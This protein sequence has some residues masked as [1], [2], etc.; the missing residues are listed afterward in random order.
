MPEIRCPVSEAARLFGSYPA[1]I[2]SQSTITYHEYDR[3]VA[4]TQ[5]RLQDHGVAAHQRVAILSENSPEY[6]ILLAAL[7]RL[8]AVAC[9]ISPHLPVLSL[10]A[11]LERIGCDVIIYASNQVPLDPRLTT[12]LLPLKDIVNETI[13]SPTSISDSF[14]SPDQDAT[15][16]ATSGTTAVPK[17]VLHSYGNHYY[18]ARGSN[19]NIRIEPGDRWLLSLPLYHVGGLAILFRAILGGGAVV[20]PG[21]R[22]DIAEAVIRH[23]VTHVSVVSTHLYRLLHDDLLFISAN[24]FKAVLAGG[25]PIGTGLVTQAH[26]RGWPIHTTYGLTEMSS[27]VATTRTGDTLDRLLTSG[28]TLPY[29]ESKVSPDGE[30]MVKGETLFRGYVDGPGVFLP[31]DDNGW[32]ATGDMGALDADG[33]LAVFGRKDNMFIS[34]GENIH[35]EEIEG[36]LLS[37][38]GIADA[39]VV[40][41]EDEQFGQRPAAFV[42]T[43]DDATITRDTLVAHV[44]TLLPRFKLP[45]CFY[46]WPAA[47]QNISVKPRRAYLRDLAATGGATEMT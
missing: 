20:F 6:V 21:T 40:P 30:I 41:I 39:L 35:P 33:Y 5:S 28:R 7:F 38:T 23:R 42:R 1:L 11:Y 22:S 46:R 34:G 15:V 29:R 45:V 32:F 17:A 16:L 12:R 26:K 36:A 27:Q 4:A 9:P 25:G 8:G 10:S 31:V 2:T 18:S 14:V 19:E 43:A 44:A 24:Y 13:V 47:P 37:V 3:L